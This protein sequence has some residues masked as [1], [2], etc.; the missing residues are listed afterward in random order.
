MIL[1][2][3]GS[4]YIGSHTCVELAR[5]G[6][7]FIVFDNFCNSTPAVLDRMARII[8]RPVLLHEGDIRDSRALDRVFSDHPIAA[9]LHFA[10]LKAVTESIG[11]P[12]TYF[13]NNVHG[14]IA[15]IDAMRRASCKTIVF[16]SS[17]TVYGTEQPMPV[18]ETASCAV[19]NPYGRTKLVV[20]GLLHDLHYSDPEWR[21]AMLRYFNPAGAHSSGLI[22]ESSLGSPSNLVPLVS[23]VAAGVRP[24]VQIF[25]GDYPSVDGTGVRDFV[26]VM[27]LAEGHLA[28]LDFLTRNKGAITVNLGTG[29]GTSVLEL[30]HAFERASGRSIPYEIVERRA[31]DID[32][33]FAAVELAQELLG[34]VATRNIDDMCSDAWRWQRANWH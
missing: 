32:I 15:L 23:L 30:I 24:V 26:H 1:V 3:G 13:D 20:E 12:L 14:S 18:A 4:G 33:S 8:G 19:T 16:S 25:G 9:V 34:W 10:G 17:A 21:I 2:T 22:G 6:H 31:A 7:E 27:D 29:R 11:D 28:A 5:A